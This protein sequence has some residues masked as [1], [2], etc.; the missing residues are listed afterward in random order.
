[1]RNLQGTNMKLA[2]KSLGH[3]HGILLAA[4]LKN[5]AD[6]LAA[7]IKVVEQNYRPPLNGLW[8]YAARVAKEHDLLEDAIKR[9]DKNA[10]KEHYHQREDRIESLAKVMSRKWSGLTKSVKGHT[11]GHTNQPRIR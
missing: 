4:G 2:I 7:C 1:M 10:V 9:N 11:K 5:A 6:S 8:S 3:I